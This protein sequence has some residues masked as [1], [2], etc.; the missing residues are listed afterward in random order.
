MKAGQ[1]EDEDRDGSKSP[2]TSDAE[3]SSTDPA[4]G[5]PICAPGT[6]LDSGKD[7][8]WNESRQQAGKFRQHRRPE[9]AGTPIVRPRQVQKKALKNQKADCIKCEPPAEAQA[10][11]P[12]EQCAGVRWSARH[13]EFRGG[14]I[15]F[16]I[17]RFRICG[18]IPTFDIEVRHR[19]FVIAD[20]FPQQP[21]TW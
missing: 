6:L 5:Q 19:R 10:V 14:S 4:W 21:P 11:R 20:G 8:R 2:Q 13:G 12:E 18:R 7:E 1:G 15:R 3:K 9:A 17:G 16:R